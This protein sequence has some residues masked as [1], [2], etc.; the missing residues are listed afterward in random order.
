MISFSGLNAVVLDI[1]GTTC[2][3]DFVAGTLFPYAAEQL[4]HYLQRHGQ[5]DPV[6]QLLERVWGAWEQESDPDAPTPPTGRMPTE[7]VPYLQWLIAQDRKFTPLKDLQ[8]QIWADG[9]GSGDLRAPLFP[10]VAAALARWQG[11]GLQLAVYSSGSVQAQQLLYGHS[12]SGDLR[13]FFE[14]WFDTKVGS[15]LES[16]SYLMLCAGLRQP[17]TAV[18][19]LSDSNAELSAAAA[20]GLQVCGCQRLGN[21]EA[22][23]ASWPV[24]EQLSSLALSPAAV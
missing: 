22:I 18:L 12:S 20:A 10:D 1:E 21:P 16:N 23:A 7:A 13:H 14:S 4:P 6:Q 19:F 2:P 15:K 8:G 3:V 11:L 5:S 9:Y 17:P 24:V